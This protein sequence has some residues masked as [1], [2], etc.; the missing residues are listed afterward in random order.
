V[1]V[2]FSLDAL[3]RGD[4]DSRSKFYTR[5]F[6]LGALSTNDIL[7]LEN[8]NPIGTDGDTRYV[9]G[10]LMALGSTGVA[11]GAGAGAVPESSDRDEAAA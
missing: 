4:S 8:H 9:P 1:F 10:N 5:M 7:K 3:L 11:A 6:Q 2:E